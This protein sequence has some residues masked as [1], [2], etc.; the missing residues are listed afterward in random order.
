MWKKPLEQ[1][2]WKLT[3][4]SIVFV[5]L[6]IFC[7]NTLI[8]KI[9]FITLFKIKYFNKIDTSPKR[10]YRW[11]KDM[12]K[13]SVSLI[14]REMQIK[15]TMRYHLT[16]VRIAVIKQTNARED[17]EKRGLFSLLVGM[18]TGAAIVESSMRYFKKIKNASAF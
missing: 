6:F 4:I 15:T 8:Y 18:R 2:N 11:L 10:T 14:I 17:V 13:C 9:L 16:P 3:L 7:Q 12:K 1:Q 5:F